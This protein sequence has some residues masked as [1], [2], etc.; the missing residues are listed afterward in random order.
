MTL[1]TLS[2]VWGL[3][4]ERAETFLRS[5]QKAMNLCQQLL[6]L[7]TKPYRVAGGVYPVSF[8]NLALL[9][10]K[11]L[12]VSLKPLPTSHPQLLGS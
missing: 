2:G 11:A 6:G 8:Q 5:M 12:M 3:S 4:R 7:F 10:P 1:G 9:R